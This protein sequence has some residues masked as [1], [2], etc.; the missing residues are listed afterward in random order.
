[1]IWKVWRAV[2]SIKQVSQVWYLQVEEFYCFREDRREMSSHL[3]STTQSDSG[4]DG[5]DD[6]QLLVTSGRNLRKVT[7]QDGDKGRLSFWCMILLI[8]LLFSID[9]GRFGGSSSTFKA[10][11]RPLPRCWGEK[12]KLCRCEEVAG[13]AEGFTMHRSDQGGSAVAD[14]GISLSVT[15]DISSDYWSKL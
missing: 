9:V 5:A 14:H 7:K 13:F 11:G 8:L 15:G 10:V 2:G 6:V 4:E 12:S 3:H 1:M